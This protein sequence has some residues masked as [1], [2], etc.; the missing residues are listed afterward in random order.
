MGLAPENHA[1]LDNNH[2]TRL[3]DR[4]NRMIDR[5]GTSKILLA[6][7]KTILAQNGEKAKNLLH[8]SLL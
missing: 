7:I 4:T 1:H 8:S 6:L 3:Y 2:F 5:K